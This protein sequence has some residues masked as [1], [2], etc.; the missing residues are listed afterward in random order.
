MKPIA[1][2]HAPS[3]AARQCYQFPSLF[4]PPLAVGISGKMKLGRFGRH[5]P[6]FE[7]SPKTMPGDSSI[8]WR[9][10]LRLKDS[11]RILS[12][13]TAPAF[14]TNGIGSSARTRGPL[15]CTPKI[16]ANEQAV[17]STHT[18]DINS[19]ADEVNSA[20]VSGLRIV[21]APIG[22]PPKPDDIKMF[23][24][25]SNLKQR[26]ASDLGVAL[27]EYSLLVAFISVVAWGSVNYFGSSAYNEIWVINGEVDGSGTLPQGFGGW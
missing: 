16:S 21:I 7:Q 9:G 18:P 12:A 1:P 24:Y 10:S 8:C 13:A 3:D 4:P 26:A 22:A 19:D 23:S 14:I 15:R 17:G 5:R 11:L 25:F 27:V 20:V 2:A 6:R